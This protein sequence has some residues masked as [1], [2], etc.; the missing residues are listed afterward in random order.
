MENSASLQSQ[1][2]RFVMT[3]DVQP[4][5]SKRHV[6]CLKSLLELLQ[7]DPLTRLAKLDVDGVENVVVS[8]AEGRSV[9]CREHFHTMLRRFLPWA[10]STGLMPTNLAAAVPRLR[11]ARLAHAPAPIADT[12]ARALLKSID[13]NCPAGR[14]DYAMILCLHVYG[15]RGVQLR[16]LCLADIDWL[17]DQIHF[18]A[19]KYSRSVLAPLFP[20][21]GNAII[22]YLRHARKLDTPHDELFLTLTGPIRPLAGGTLSG[23]VS[24]CLKRADIT[25]DERV[26]KGTH[27][28]RY[29]CATRLLTHSQSL[30]V[31]QDCLGHCCMD[32]VQIY[33]KLDVESLRKLAMPWPQPVAGLPPLDVPPVPVVVSVSRHSTQTPL[34]SALALSIRR[35]LRQKRASNCAFV[36]GE[37]QLRR[38]DR[39]FCEAGYTEPLLSRESVQAYYQTLTAHSAATQYAHMSVL[40]QF[41]AYHHLRYPESYVIT[42]LPVRRRDHVRFA[43]L[44]SGHVHQI[45]TAA[46]ELLYN[47]APQTWACLMGLVY[48]CGLRIG[49]AL[50]MRV[51][52]FAPSRQ[53]LF[54]RAGKD[55]KQ[56][57]TPL[58]G[59]AANALQLHL[60]RQY[61]SVCAPDQALFTTLAGT[62]LTYDRVYRSFRRVTHR[63]NYPH[64]RIHDLRHSFATTAFQRAATAGQDIF[65]LLP[66]LATFLG[67]TSYAGSQRYVHSDAAY[68]QQASGGFHQAFQCAIASTTSEVQS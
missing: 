17:N 15:V 1:Y 18:P 23:R 24:R 56:R 37:L 2:E 66:Y 10:A 65:A 36:A 52:D 61:G 3:R 51:R 9:R 34:Q 50:K 13:H 53:T 8:Y 30:K 12:H 14:R 16:N 31:V 68:L 26:R 41:S 57:L 28:F 39:F 49:E 7:P 6:A 60:Q 22:D 55:S 27:A 5:T 35:F 64:L 45:M 48:C 32:S 25:L 38:L 46:P 40:R 43:L 33:N 42:A 11:R 29:A 19:A 62:T 59:C 67:H 54:V 58:T 47:I 21:V 4:Q 63:T 20:E 44:T